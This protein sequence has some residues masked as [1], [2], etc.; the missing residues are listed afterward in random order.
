MPTRYRDGKSVNITSC[1]LAS[2]FDYCE[3]P[4]FDVAQN[5]K[6]WDDAMDEEMRAPPKNETFDL[7]FQSPKV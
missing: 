3:L 1:F 5:F 7:L 6:Q 2:S 4:C